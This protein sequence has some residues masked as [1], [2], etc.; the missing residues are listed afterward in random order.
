MPYTAPDNVASACALSVLASF[1]TTS[2]VHF[3]RTFENAAPTV[4]LYD[5][6]IFCASGTTYLTSVPASSSL[7]VPIG[8]SLNSATPLL[9]VFAVIFTVFPD[10]EVPD[11]LN[12]IFAITPSSEDLVTLTL[13][14]LRIFEKATFVVP[15]AVTVTVFDAGVMIVSG[16]SSSVTV[17]V[18]GARVCDTFPE[19]SVVTVRLTPLP[20]IL[21]LMPATLPISDVLT[22]CIVPASS[23]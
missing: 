13:P 3:L 2:A 15:P 7:Y 17:Y 18:P 20:L 6:V 8:I 5:I 19:L 22:I 23:A 4:E 11:S 21:N 14:F 12:V 10:V 9:S 16:T 1:F